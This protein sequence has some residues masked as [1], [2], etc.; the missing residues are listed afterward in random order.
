MIDNELMLNSGG[1]ILYYILPTIALAITSFAQLLITSNYGKYKKIAA[2][3]KKRGCDVARQILD[4]HGLKNVKVEEVEGN[5]TDHYDPKTKTV[6]LS[7]EIYGE[8]TIAAVS[9][10]AHECGHAIQDKVG[11][12]P[13]RMRSK[14][15]PVVNF[16][17]KIGYLIITSGLVMGALKLAGIGLIMLLSMLAFQLVTLPVEFDASRRGKQELNSLMILNSSEQ[18]GASKMLR[19][20]AFTYVASVLSTLMEI[21]R[22]AAMILTNKKR[23]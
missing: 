19:A 10:A 23:K 16:S 9:V 7:T 12:A 21:L 5:L 4:K 13:M 2:S 3:S 15:V 8:S 20:A 22:F 11:Y 14:L 1:G 18:T 6:R 17:T